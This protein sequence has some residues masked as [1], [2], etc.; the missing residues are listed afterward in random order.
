[1]SKPFLN[2]SLDRAGLKNTRVGVINKL[3]T[4]TENCL[5]WV[6]MNLIFR[7]YIL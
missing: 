5:K 4:M 2:P 1:V 7:K 6:K 3:S